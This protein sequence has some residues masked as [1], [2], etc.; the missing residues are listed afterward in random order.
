MMHG[1]LAPPGCGNK[2]V[3]DVGTMSYETPETY[4]NDLKM[5]LAV[6]D[7]AASEQRRIL[8][9]P[10][11]ANRLAWIILRFCYVLCVF[12]RIHGCNFRSCRLEHSGKKFALTSQ[13]HGLP[14]GTNDPSDCGV[15]GSDVQSAIFCIDRQR[16]R[17]RM[18]TWDDYHRSPEAA[19][20]G[21]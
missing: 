8:C 7:E 10:S 13:A 5:S 2:L 14:G 1:S 16:R 15:R 21:R 18:R 9:G 6:S 4:M 3:F 20:E 11:T 12:R 17:A 19:G